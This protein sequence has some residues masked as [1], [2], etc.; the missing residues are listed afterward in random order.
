MRLYFA[1]PLFCDSE[2]RF[3]SDLAEKIEALEAEAASALKHDN[4]CTIQGIRETE[5]GQLSI[6]R[7]AY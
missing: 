7:A 6:V 3:N 4:I 1:A 5:D 2:R